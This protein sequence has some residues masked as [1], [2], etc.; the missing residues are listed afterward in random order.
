[1]RGLAQ[2]F[3]RGGKAI[4]RPSEGPGPGSGEGG[5]LAHSL[6]VENKLGMAPMAARPTKRKTAR[7]SIVPEPPKSQPMQLKPAMA[8]MPQLSPPKIS[9]TKQIF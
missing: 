7:A 2:K 9:R 8:R 3:A 1:M 4:Y 6:G 5:V